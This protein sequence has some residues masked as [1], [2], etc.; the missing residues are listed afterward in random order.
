MYFLLQPLEKGYLCVEQ[1][2]N[3]AD[4][5]E[6]VEQIR[7]EDSQC[8]RKRIFSKYIPHMYSDG[9]PEDRV[10]LIKGEIVEPREVKHVVK[11]EVD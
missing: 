2:N 4:A 11:Y 3:R 5:E 8:S 1:I 6:K 9:W 10:L 7:E